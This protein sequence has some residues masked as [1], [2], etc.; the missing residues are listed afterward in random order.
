MTVEHDRPRI[1]RPETGCSPASLTIRKLIP[2]QPEQVFSAWTDPH[3]L[4]VWW[5]PKG[6]QCLSAEIDLTVGGDYR[7]ENELP[8]Q[9]ILWIV[10]RFEVIERPDLLVYTWGLDAPASS[11]E[12]VSVSF[13]KHKDGTEIVLL[14]EM[15]PEQALAEQHLEGW[16]GCLDGLHEFAAAA[17]KANG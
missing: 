10:G 15:I 14:H 8:D 16:Q 1:I 6:V 5:G 9:S 2:A 7:I 12:R 4:K 11:T 3:A 13:N 17:E